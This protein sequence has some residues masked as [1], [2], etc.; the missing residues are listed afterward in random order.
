MLTFPIPL[1][2]VSCKKWSLVQKV[3]AAIACHQARVLSCS[4]EQAMEKLWRNCLLYTDWLVNLLRFQGV[5][6]GHE[7]VKSSC[8]CFPR[9]LVSFVHPRVLVSFDPQH[10]FS[11]NRKTYLSWEVSQTSLPHLFN[12]FNWLL[13]FCS[14]P[15]RRWNLSKHYRSLVF[16]TRKGLKSWV[17]KFRTSVWTSRFSQ[18]LPDQLDLCT[19]EQS[20]VC[21]VKDRS[22]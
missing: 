10:M 22:Q 14:V 17:Q 20:G 19:A 15:F 11:S 18:W 16:L 5:W 12:T 21:N 7:R 1:S 4:H 8:S 3:Y 13:I 2:S 6:P 9:E